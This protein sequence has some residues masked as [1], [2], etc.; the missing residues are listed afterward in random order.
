MSAPRSRPIV[1]EVVRLDVGGVHAQAQEGVDLEPRELL[2][3]LVGR[4]ERCAHA[5][6]V[7]RGDLPAVARGEVGRPLDER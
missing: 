5:G 2:R 4:V 3:K 6:G 7:E 1:G